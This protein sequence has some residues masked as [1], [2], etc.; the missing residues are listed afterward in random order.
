MLTDQLEGL[1][2]SNSKE[3]HIAIIETRAKEMMWIQAVS[4]LLTLA[5]Y[6]HTCG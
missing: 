2:H 4:K 6:C 1:Y 3:R 5:K